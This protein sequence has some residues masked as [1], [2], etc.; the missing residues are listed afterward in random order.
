M[1]GRHKLQELTGISEQSIRTS[2]ERL[3]S[4]SEITI[5]STNHFSI[6]TLC[7]YENYQNNENEINQQN[8]QQSNKPAT[9]NQPASNH[10]QECKE[11]KN[12]KNKD[13]WLQGFGFFYTAY[14]RHAGKDKAVEAWLKLKPNEEL[15][16]IILEAIETQKQ[17]EQWL[18]NKGQF[19][20]YPATWL[21][22]RRWEDEVIKYE[23]QG[24]I[25]PT[26]VVL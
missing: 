1:T 26:K 14:P 19:I 15:Q 21:N 22:G 11:L 24:T 12:E 3:K 2:L 16:K 7:N 18:K 23:E 4:T 6:I 25:W 8:N 13:Y 17:S 20:P 10:K 9:S 5:K